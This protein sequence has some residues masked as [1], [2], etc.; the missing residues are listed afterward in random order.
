MK[1][2][3]IVT[4]DDLIVH[5]GNP[6]KG[7]LNDIIMLRELDL[8]QKFEEVYKKEKESEYFVLF[9]NKTYISLT[10]IISPFPRKHIKP[11]KRQWNRR[12]KQTRITIK[13][14]FRQIQQ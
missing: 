2:Q 8:K 13:N 7:R 12:I 1:Y 3:G 14:A 10:R 11:H 9:E 5:F 4:P 6:F